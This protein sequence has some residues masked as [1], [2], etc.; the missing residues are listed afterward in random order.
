MKY[1][2]L[3]YDVAA[4]AEPSEDEMARWFAVDA[5]THS[6]GVN[7]GGEA[8]TPVETAKT[9]R[10]RGGRPEVKDGPFAETKEQLGGFYILD[11]PDLDAA[12]DWA[13]KF[14]NVE[15]GSVEIRPV[16]DFSAAQQ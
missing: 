7:Q 11:L 8:L 2:F 5:E 9:V 16:I 12:I 1:A 14:P 15:S 10:V 6:A 3:L 4:G 13:R